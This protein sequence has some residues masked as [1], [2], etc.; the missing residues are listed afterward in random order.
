MTIA[1]SLLP[2]FDQEMANT[3]RML[4]RVPEGKND[5]R[6]HKKSMPLGRIATHLAELPDWVVKAITLDELDIAPPGGEPFTPTIL[7]TPEE[8]VALLD[9]TAADAREHIAKTDDASMM[10]GWTLKAGGQ[11]AFTMP[12]I[13]VIRSFV[14]NHV[15]HHRGQL[16]VYLRLLGQPLP[17]IYGP[18]ADE[19][20]M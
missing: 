19:S 1:E 10:K 7:S 12:K 16:S 2:E 8:M 6:P 14:L 3:R 11:E 17:P 20:P 9:K 5:W 13:A 18:S 15:I 4:E